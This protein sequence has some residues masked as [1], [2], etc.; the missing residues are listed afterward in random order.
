MSIPEKGI[1]AE[2]FSKLNEPQFKPGDAVCFTWFNVKRYGYV[3][4]FKEVNWGIQYTVTLGRMSYPCGIEVN[5]WKT[6]YVTGLI[7]YD[8][9][10]K[11]GQ[12]KTKSNAESADPMYQTVTYR[13]ES[14]N[15]TGVEPETTRSD[16]GD[17]A[18]GNEKP[19]GTKRN[20]KPNNKV[21]GGNTTETSTQKPRVKTG[22][23]SKPDVAEFGDD[24]MYPSDQPIGSKTRKT[25]KSSVEIDKNILSNFF[26]NI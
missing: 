23:H 21:R 24:G 4:T 9:T 17:D 1:P 16:S 14:S 5:G 10:I 2:I 6:K 3:K 13:N 11:L 12:S 19:M 15:D 7:Q 22:G 18:I 25:K 26:K 8:E 20:S